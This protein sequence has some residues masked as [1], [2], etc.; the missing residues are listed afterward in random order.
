MSAQVILAFSIYLSILLTIGLSAYHKQTSSEDFLLGG[1]S[2]NYWV[3]AISAHA[4]D[5]SGWLFIGVPSMI[6]LHGL[7]QCWMVIGLFAGMFCC[8]Q[9]VAPRLRS[10]T[11]KYG[12]LTLST[13]FAKRYNDTSKVIRLTTAFMM[14]IFFTFYVGSGFLT[15]G[16]VSNSAFGIPYHT[17]ITVGALCV[18]A[19]TVVGGFLAVAWTDLFQGLFLLAMILLVPFCAFFQIDGIDHIRS[20]AQLKN[21]PLTLLP[22][23]SVAGLFGGL[24]IAL[25]WGL[26]YF[27]QPHIL[28]KFM[29]IKDVKEM[30]KSQLVG[31]TWQFL[32]LGAAVSIGLIAIAFFPE[33]LADPQQ[34]FTLMVNKL[35]SPFF[36]AFI[37][38]AI[39][40]AAIST[41]DSQVL[42]FA[43][44]FAEDIYRDSI[45]PKATPAQMIWV[46]RLGILLITTLAYGIAYYEAR[47]VHA[48]VQYAW[49]GLGS[50]FG[51]LLLFSLY[52][53]R[54]TYA[55]AL[56]GIL[57]GGIISGLWPYTGLLFSDYPLVPGF[58]ISAALIFIVS[59]MTCA[60]HSD[61]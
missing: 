2:L 19:Y 53:K 55:G 32:T 1:R 9:F 27:G 10:Q 11:E 45:N 31:M 38:C 25:G 7:S 56:T 54:V 42:V 22:S 12:A 30:K 3:T 49:S 46:S 23:N 5:M 48:V 50:S 47:S 35:F 21:I 16:I 52:S 15:M 28:S 6:Y 8:W 41:I 44:V 24:Y 34:I 4:S 29:A 14:L 57:S 43:S 20:V 36:A 60:K 18:V 37:L 58:F 33:G 61:A 17:A 39:L 59:Q 40:A 13:Y 51:P 26:G